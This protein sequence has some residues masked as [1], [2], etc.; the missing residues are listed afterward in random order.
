MTV[1]KSLHRSS[2]RNL[3]VKEFCY[4]RTVNLAAA[5]CKSKMRAKRLAEKT[6]EQERRKN[7]IGGGYIIVPAVYLFFF[8]DCEFYIWPAIFPLPAADVWISRGRK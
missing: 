4:L 2:G 1:R 6:K 8:C 7:S 5:V 3:P